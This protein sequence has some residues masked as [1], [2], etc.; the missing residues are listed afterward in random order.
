MSPPRLA[1]KTWNDM[2]EAEATNP[3]RHTY[4]S[5]FLVMGYKLRGLVFNPVSFI[6]CINPV[7]CILSS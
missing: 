5:T 3:E 6:L 4:F 2:S 1:V 7:S